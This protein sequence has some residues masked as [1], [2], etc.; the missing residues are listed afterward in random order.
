MSE[1][2][3]HLP[4]YRG[5]IVCG[6][7]GTNPNTMNL[8]FRVTETGVEVPFKAEPRQ[9][10]YRGIVHG[11]VLCASL[12]ET[13][14][15]SV[16]VDRK[17]YFVT[18]ELTVRFLRPLQIGQPVLVRGRP[19]EHKSRYSDAEGEIVDADG[20]IYARATGRFFAMPD[21]EAENVRRYLSFEDGDLDVLEAGP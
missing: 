17:C 21:S 6:E 2:A 4:T 9:E 10:G 1:T 14:G 12:D 3:R 18:G 11:G 16:A 7:P 13:I 5:C 20:N 8:R 19:K 15:W